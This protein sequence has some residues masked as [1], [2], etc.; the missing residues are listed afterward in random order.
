[1][2]LYGSCLGIGCLVF[3][4]TQH[5]VRGP[6]GVMTELDF[7]R[8]TFCSQKGENVYENLFLNFILNLVYNGSLY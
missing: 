7:L 4:G 3:N 2:L 5:D 1:M 8:K 6:Y